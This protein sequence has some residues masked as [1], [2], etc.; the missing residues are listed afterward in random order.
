MR[1]SVARVLV[2]AALWGGAA[3]VMAEPL[4]DVLA[5][6]YLASPRL[7]AAR[8]GLRAADEAVARA[9]AGGRPFVAGSSSVGGAVGGGGSLYQRQALTLTQSLYSG[10]GNAAAIARAEN[11]V[12]AERARL[13]QVEQE[14][15]LEAVAAY[16][17]VARDD[18]VLTLARRN[19]DRLRVQLDATRDRERF[20]DVT[21]TDVAQAETRFAR[22]TADRVAAEGD[23]DAARAEFARVA[24][25]APG[26]LSLPE[27]LPEPVPSLDAALTE[28]EASWRWQ[29]ASFDLATARDEVD[30]A[31]AELKP[32]VSVGAELGYGGDAAWRQDQGTGA[33]FG[34]T[35]AVPLYQGGGEFARVRQSKELLQQRRHAQ[36]EARRAAEAEIARAW[37]AV[38]T[39]D[40]AIRSLQSQVDAAGFA[41]EGVRQEALVGARLVLDVLDAEQELFAAEVDLVRAGRER[42]LAGYRLRAA[43]GKL[44]ARDLELAVAYQDPKVHHDEVSRRWFGVGG[45]MPAD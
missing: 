10:G 29:A 31:L 27:P 36:D 45:A 12:L 13:G 11:A 19:E 1:R 2:L 4:A 24:G 35:V 3:P 14:V 23:L 5:K 20:G 26:P 34:A 30:L 42:V 33:S 9:R 8:A 16:T 41:L 32:K 17:A 25:A 15:L 21:R 18:A 7:E 37:Q 38:R 39:A 6:V 22:A 44:T 40:A 28:A 43:L